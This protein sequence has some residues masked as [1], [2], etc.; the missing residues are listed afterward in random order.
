MSSC[1]QSTKY[2]SQILASQLAPSPLPLLTVRCKHAKSTKVLIGDWR[3]GLQRFQGKSPEIIGKLTKFWYTFRNFA[4]FFLY[5]F[6]IT[7]LSKSI[8][9]LM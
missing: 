3:K 5:L 2:A 1:V 6:G 9:K 8:L 7:D 4:L